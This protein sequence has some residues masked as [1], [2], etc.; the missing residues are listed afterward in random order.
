MFADTNTF[1]MKY[2]KFMPSSS[3]ALSF[4]ALGILFFAGLNFYGQYLKKKMASAGQ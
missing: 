2:R 4:L 3:K 1:Y